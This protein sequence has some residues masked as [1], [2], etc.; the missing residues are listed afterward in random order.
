M[1][2]IGCMGSRRALFHLKQ[3]DQ[4]LIEDFLID[5]RGGLTFLNNLFNSKFVV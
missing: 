4:G 5:G 1:K 2:E 3:F